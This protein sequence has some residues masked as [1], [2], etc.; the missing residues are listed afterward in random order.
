MFLFLSKRKGEDQQK[1]K[2]KIWIRLQ[3]KEAGQR[4][5][6]IQFLSRQGEEAGL[7]K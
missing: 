5:L 4:R 3:R 1:S 2:L 7:Q 6:K